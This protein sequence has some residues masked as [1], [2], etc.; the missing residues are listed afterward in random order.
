MPKKSK[1]KSKLRLS[2][3][4]SRD[5]EELVAIDVRLP[6]ALRDLSTL[7]DA[8]HAAAIDIDKRVAAEVAAERAK[9]HK[10]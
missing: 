10:K 1:S 8:L 7:A 5:G 3:Q 9:K 4:A 6:M 2:I